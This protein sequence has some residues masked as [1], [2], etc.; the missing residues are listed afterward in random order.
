MGKIIDCHENN[1][2]IPENKDNLIIENKPKKEINLPKEI[3]PPKEIKH[4]KDCI[5]I[6][7]YMPRDHS[8]P[9]NYI[10]GDRACG[11]NY[12]FRDLYSQIHKKIKNLYVITGLPSKYSDLT[13]NIYDNLDAIN[14]LF[15]EP[16]ENPSV[17]V[18]DNM[19]SY[20]KSHEPI[21]N[22]LF[23]NSKNY[24][25]TIYFISNNPHSRWMSAENREKV[26][27]IFIFGEYKKSV[28]QKLH[29]QFPTKYAFNEFEMIYHMITKGKYGC[30]VIDNKKDKILWFKANVH[31]LGSIPAKNEKVL[32]ATNPV[33]KVE[34]HLDE[35]NNIKTQ[36]KQIKSSCSRLLDQIEGNVNPIPSSTLVLSSSSSSSPKI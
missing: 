36:L 14:Q 21:I 20:K 30:L 4:K 9:I 16:C 31:Q 11:K 29:A 3:K 34:L 27:R 28:M 2:N 18:I 35:I 13:T 19:Y 5:D 10:I 12:L 32:L 1:D 6:P 24:K 33:K 17:L 8:S 7:L 15:T 23:Q 26:D 25:V 22:N